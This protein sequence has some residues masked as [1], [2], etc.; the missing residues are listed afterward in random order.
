MWRNAAG[1]GVVLVSLAMPAAGRDV[2]RPSFSCEAA[3]APLDL[4]ICGNEGLSR[5][6]ALLADLYR[7]HLEQS[8]SEEERRARVQAQRQWIAQRNGDCRSGDAAAECLSAQYGQRVADLHRA[9]HPPEEAELAAAVEAM[10]SDPDRA[11]GLLEP[12]R[13]ATARLDLMLFLH[14]FRPPGPERDERIRSIQAGIDGLA[15]PALDPFAREV[16]GPPTPYDGSDAS[17]VWTVIAVPTARL[18]DGYA[19][20]CP[21]LQRRPGLL[22][23]TAPRF[24][25]SRDNFLPQSGCDQGRGT[26]EGFPDADVER[27]MQAAQAADG[28]FLALHPGTVRFAI[29]AQQAQQLQALK[30]TPS[31]ILSEP[32]PAQ[33]T[34]YRTW[35][36]LA[37]NN[38]HVHPGVAAAYAQ[39]HAALSAFY[40]DAGLSGDEAAEAARR[41]LFMLVFG[42]DC[43]DAPPPRS[44]RTMILDGASRDDVSAFLTRGSWQDA[45][46]L[47]PFSRCAES[48]GKDPLIHLAVTRPELLD[49]LA[50]LAASVPADRRNALD[51]DMEPQAVNGFGKTPLMSAAQWD[52]L[53]GLEWL[54]ARGV[55]VDAATSAPEEFGEGPRHGL[56]TALMYAAANA[57]LPVIRRLLDAGADKELR[58]SQGLRAHDYLTGNGP[59]PANP[60]LQGPEREQAEE[61]LR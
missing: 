52:S 59:V 48:A 61:L 50:A 60:L 28:N 58:D 43:G 2:A 14:A 57:S 32:P 10:T 12:L 7:R 35:S 29:A 21:V 27:F 11:E 42:A 8:G 17:L 4:A 38:R 3:R 1:M 55:E 30:L 25:S 18:A 40:A 53:P 41:G 26:V 19:L 54:L 5:Q 44:L 20:P 16:F 31:E 22:E 36:Y 15:E 51:L 6:D 46:M 45:A 34:P 9:V 24:G 49:D 33:T 23:A 56:R 13:S 37:V 47:E 39:A